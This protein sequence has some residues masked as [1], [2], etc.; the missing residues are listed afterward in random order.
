MVYLARSSTAERVALKVIGQEWTQD[1]QFRARFELEAAAARMVHSA[2]TAPMVDADP[3]APLP[4]LATL[5][6]PGVSLSVRVRDDGPMAEEELRVLALGLSRA[7]QDIHRTGVVHRD[8]KPTNVLL[9]EDGPCLIDFGV[10]RAVDGNSLTQTGQVV[11]TPPFMAPEQFTA[12][13]KVGPGADVFSLG[14]PGVGPR[15]GT[16]VPR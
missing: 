15:C 6:V 3:Y 16:G 12:A 5:F 14:S 1:S 9:T 7:L 8:L 4:W 2:C 13:P 10:A 11:G